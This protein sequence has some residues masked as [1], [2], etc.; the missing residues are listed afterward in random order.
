MNKINENMLTTEIRDQMVCRISMAAKE[1]DDQTLQ[2][3]YLFVIH[4]Q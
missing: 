4:L 3:I 1:A 2:K